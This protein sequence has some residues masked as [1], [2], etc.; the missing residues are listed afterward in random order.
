MEEMK[1]LEKVEEMG[2]LEKVKEMGKMEEEDLK[3]LKLLHRIEIYPGDLL[4]T[5]Y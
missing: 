1:E 3:R 4:V 2:E 5:F